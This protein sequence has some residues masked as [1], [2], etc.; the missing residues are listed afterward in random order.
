MLALFIMSMIMAIQS[1][2]L[3]ESLSDVI[4]DSTDEIE[5]VVDTRAYTDFYFYNYIPLTAEYAVNDASYELGQEGGGYDW[6]NN[7]LDGNSFSH[8]YL[9]WVDKSEKKLN[10]EV[11]GSEGACVIPEVEYSVTPFDDPDADDTKMSVNAGPTE[12]E[13]TPLQA[14]CVTSSGETRYL[15]EDDTYST[16]T[17]AV[18]NRYTNLAYETVEAFKEIR[19][20]LDNVKSVTKE[21]RNCGSY[22][23][24]SSVEADAAQTLDNN[25]ES[26]L[27]TSI[28]SF[29]T[30]PEFELLVADFSI[31]STHKHGY[32]SNV[33]DANVNDDRSSGSCCSGCSPD[34]SSSFWKYTEVTVKPDN[35]NIDWVI[36]DEEFEVIVEETYETLEFSVEPY[37]HDW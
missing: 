24:Y 7:W 30:V 11:D 21:H 13:E 32:E 8:L 27:Q 5:R 10:N 35:T 20:N 3:A 19:D 22:P 33:V 9:A 16:T 2:P 12:E 1:L 29:P 15:S 14:R 31:S 23:S 36:E 25:L 37:T 28:S 17:Y 6:D 34:S 18:N 4:G 26:A